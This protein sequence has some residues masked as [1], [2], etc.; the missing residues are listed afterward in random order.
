LGGD[1]VYYLVCNNN[2]PDN[3]GERKDLEIEIPDFAHDRTLGLSITYRASCDPNNE[4]KVATSLHSDN[5][6][7]GELNKKM[8]RWV[9][10]LTRDNPSGFI[11]N[12]VEQVNRLKTALK[13]KAS[14][15]VG[16]RLDV[17]IS[18]TQAPHLVFSK[19]EAFNIA[20]NNRLV[21]EIVDIANTRKLGIALAYRAGYEAEDRDKA[22]QALSS[23]RP[24]KE[25]IEQRIKRWVN[26]FTRNAPREFIDNYRSKVRDLQKKLQER[27]KEETGLRL[28]LSITLEKQPES[29]KI[30]PAEITVYVKDSD[31]ALD[32]KFETELLVANEV[33]ATSSQWGTLPLTKL[34]KDEIKN[35]LLKEITI[36]QFFYE[37]KD[38][39]RNNLV[40][41]LNSILVDKGRQIGYLSLESKAISSSSIPKEL[42]EIQH[43]VQC[44][45]QNYS[46]FIAVENTLQ[47]LPQDV[48]RYVSAQ[49]P[50]LQTWVENKLEKIIKPLLLEKK[51][52]ELLKDFQR[53]SEDIRQ[54]MKEEAKSIGYAVEHIVSLPRLEHHKLKDSFEIADENQ[55]FRTNTAVVTVK[56]STIVNAKVEDFSKIED[57]LNSGVDEIIEEMRKLIN[58]TTK[59]VL[60]KIDPQRFY[61]HFY[62]AETTQEKSVEQELK[63][64]ITEAL[65]ERFGLKINSVVPIPEQ[66]EIMEYMQRIMGMPGTFESE[67]TSTNG[68]ESVKFT[69]DF[70]IS[71]IEKDRWSRFESRFL[72]MQQSR[73]ELRQEL[74]S[75]KEEHANIISIGDIG[76]SNSELQRIR[77]R[78]TSIEG[79]LF[80]IQEIKKCIEDSILDNLFATID[81][82]ALQ[83]LDERNKLAIALKIQ[84]WAKASV[85]EKYGLTIKITG[86]RRTETEEEK[87]RAQLRQATTQANLEQSLK[88]IEESAKQS[89]LKLEA[90]TKHRENQMQISLKMYEDKSA[91]LQELNQ[92]RQKLRL[93]GDKISQEELKDVEEQIKILESEMIDSSLEDDDD[94]INLNLLKP[95][96]SRK[97]SF[98]DEMKRRELP[99]SQ[100][101]PSSQSII[102]V[103]DSQNEDVWHSK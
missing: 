34:V 33:Q 25:E 93:I 87:A 100:P 17:R 1:V 80:G 98:L 73:Q 67:V 57:Y 84:E 31:T 42:I 92:K 63:D 36:S 65:K 74:T 68:G 44:K 12:Y 8:K 85:S 78:I 16:L 11:D 24:I 43:T 54:K 38:T 66:T 76:P 89:Q 75:L 64:R 20:E 91:L 45:V 48:R 27:A 23:G 9:T 70:L 61:L 69:G 72:G 96:A 59:E 21:I 99:P 7:D 53:E 81:S 71:G 37:L 35:Y 82:Q 19:P 10:E 86:L 90:K 29:F 50:N 58:S 4:I 88:Q 28:E 2:D 26:D 5:S 95:Q 41:H 39:V 101:N 77:D 40:N 32:L 62:V 15:E 83:Y 102:D 49:S 22:T 94:A 55:E 13:E 14:K 51:Y 97:T 52:I 46:G 103:S 56:L 79:Q 60:L 3:F 6:P 47:M 30:G 18:Q